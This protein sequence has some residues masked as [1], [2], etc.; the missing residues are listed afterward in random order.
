[1]ILPWTVL[2]LLLLGCGTPK[3][4]PGV[5]VVSPMPPSSHEEAPNAST[6]PIARSASPPTSTTPGLSPFVIDCLA[7]EFA[8]D[9]EY[10]GRDYEY[11]IF[12]RGLMWFLVH[13][14]EVCTAT[15]EA[16]LELVDDS[17][18]QEFRHKPVTS[19]WAFALDFPCGYSPGSTCIYL[20][21]GEAMDIR[22]LR[23]DLDA[24][25]VGRQ[26]HCFGLLLDA[27]DLTG[28]ERVGSDRT[29]PLERSNESP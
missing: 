20:A 23:T 8:D 2:F 21:R 9:L 16:L 10:V 26:G 24:F 14:G 5:G 13:R 28:F 19:L 3:L 25:L 4:A 22:Q 18:L 27:S 1:M 7:A 29:T 11:D 17:K 12:R 15:T 6:E